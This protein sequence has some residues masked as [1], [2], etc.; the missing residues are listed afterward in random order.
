[1]LPEHF[2]VADLRR[3]HEAIEGRT[4]THLSNFQTLIR[5]RWDLLR[6]PGEFDRRSKRPAQRYRYGGPLVIEGAPE[7]D[8]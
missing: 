7:G 3:I 2:T 4:F 5:S 6:V 1:M 8:G